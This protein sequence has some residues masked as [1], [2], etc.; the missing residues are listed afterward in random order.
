MAA[1]TI[2]ILFSKMLG[3]SPKRISNNKML[4]RI[5]LKSSRMFSNILFFDMDSSKLIIYLFD[6]HVLKLALYYPIQK[7]GYNGTISTTYSKKRPVVEIYSTQIWDLF[8]YQDSC[9]V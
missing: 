9:T 5:F 2:I 3:F 1:L 4:W 6:R 7:A 8:Y